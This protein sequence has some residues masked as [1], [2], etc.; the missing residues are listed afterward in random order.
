MA[1]ILTNSEEFMDFSIT[2]QCILP[3]DHPHP[4]SPAAL[5]THLFIHHSFITRWPRNPRTSN[6]K[7][8]ALSTLQPFLCLPPNQ[9]SSAQYRHTWMV[10]THTHTDMANSFLSDPPGGPHPGHS[11]D[12]LPE[13]PKAG[14]VP[15]TLPHGPP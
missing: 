2:A 10:G 7:P 4:A 9:V 12:R 15:P 6:K 13:T 14:Q 5:S 1:H 11:G 8:K 3:L